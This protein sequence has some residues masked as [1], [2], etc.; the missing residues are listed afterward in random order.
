MDRLRTLLALP[1]P[2]VMGVL[3]ITPDSFSDGGDF[4]DPDVALAR[5]QAMVDQGADIIDIGAESTRP[6]AQPVSVETEKQRLLPVLQRLRQG[7]SV[8]LSVDTRQPAVMQAVIAEG[9]DLINDVQAMQQ[10]GALA[11][12]ADAPV[13]VCLMHMRGE[14]HSMQADV[15]DYD[16]RAAV[17]QFLKQRIAACLDVGIAHERMMVDPGFGFGK[18]LDHNWMLLQHLSALVA[19]GPPVLVG[20]SRKR[21]IGEVVGRPPKERLAGSVAAAMLAVQNG[22]KIVRVHDVA[23]TVDVLRVLEKGTP[24]L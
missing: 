6:G 13:M 1:R 20:L 23:A 15:P 21:M 2:L 19:L 18:R 22:A 8:P 24:S 12:V 5:A 7:V 11:V 14:P 16:V 10:P 9:V 3:N 4:L 17:V